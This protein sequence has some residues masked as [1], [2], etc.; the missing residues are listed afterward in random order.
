[1]DT[2]KRKRR[3]KRPARWQQQQHLSNSN[4]SLL[5]APPPN[6]VPPHTADEDGGGPSTSTSSSKKK[7]ARSSS[8]SPAKKKIGSNNSKGKEKEFLIAPPPSQP[9]LGSSAR[10]PL[11]PAAVLVQGEKDQLTAGAGVVSRSGVGEL[12]FVKGQGVGKQDEDGDRTPTSGGGGEDVFGPVSPASVNLSGKRGKNLR[13]KERERDKVRK[14]L[15]RGK[16]VV[17]GK[18]THRG[19]AVGEVEYEEDHDNEG[20]DDGEDDDED[21]VVSHGD[22]SVEGDSSLNDLSILQPPHRRRDNP[23][24]RKKGKDIAHIHSRAGIA[25]GGAYKSTPGSPKGQREFD[26][27]IHDHGHESLGDEDVEDHAGGGDG[28]GGGGGV[29]DGSTVKK[30]TLK[31]RPKGL[32]RVRSV[33]QMRSGAEEPALHATEE[34]VISGKSKSKKAKLKAATTII[35]PALAPV[36]NG[37]GGGVDLPDMNQPQT[38]RSRLIALAKKLRQSFPEQR[39]ELRR[40]TIR[41]EKQGMELRGR[42]KKAFLTAGGGSGGSAQLTAKSSPKSVRKFKRSIFFSAGSESAT[43]DIDDVLLGDGADGDGMP[44]IEEDDEGL[45]PRGRPPKKSDVPIHV[46]IDQLSLLAKLFIYYCFR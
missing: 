21:D 17:V 12:L 11:L 43:A 15:L 25:G 46:F 42:G 2:P 40:V 45:D 30:Q 1:M 4:P 34:T 24:R 32:V 44:E 28:G 6:A 16:D 5:E 14:D 10:S 22:L 23:S 18:V 13:K 36:F 39:Q 3:R 35:A 29:M 33:P 41:F 8:W 37:N 20:D 7:K 27:D 26:D 9:P 31:R 38:K 19:R